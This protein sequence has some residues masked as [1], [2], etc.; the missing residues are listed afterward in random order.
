RQS[1]ENLAAGKERV[2]RSRVGFI[3]L[4]EKQALARAFNRSV[5]P[6][7]ARSD[8]GELSVGAFLK[9]IKGYSDPA[10]Y[11]RFQINGRLEVMILAC[12]FGHTSEIHLQI[13][14]KDRIQN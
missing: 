1:I 14:S 4:S 6:F 13:F 2:R 8:A 9:D 11:A 12:Q 3:R 7:N 10:M 5:R